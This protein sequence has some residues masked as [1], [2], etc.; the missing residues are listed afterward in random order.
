LFVAQFPTLSGPSVVP[1]RRF[2]REELPT[3]FR[4]LS[5]KKRNGGSPAFMRGARLSSRAARVPNFSQTASLYR[6]FSSRSPTESSSRAAVTLLIFRRSYQ[7]LS[8]IV[9]PPVP[10]CRGSEME[11]PVVPL[12]PSDLTAPNKSHYPPLCHL[13]ACDFFDLFVF[14]ADD[15]MVLDPHHGIVIPRACDFFVLFVFFADDP[16]FL[17]PTTDS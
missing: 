15:P 4:T 6:C 16:M 13:R 2:P 14:F 8:E 17:I 10:A 9:I 7:V 5:R 11:G 12:G 1:K 3:S